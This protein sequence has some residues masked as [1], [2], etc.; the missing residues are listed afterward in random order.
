MTLLD[1]WLPVG[2]GLA[3]SPHCAQMCG[4]L[5]LAYS[6]GS[7]SRLRAHLFYNVGRIATYSLLGAVAGALGAAMGMIGKLAGIEQA[8][9][10]AAG[11]LLILAGFLTAGLVPRSGLAS[12]ANNRIASLFHKK[13]NR[14]IT[15]SNPL[16]K[17]GL[18]IALGFLPCG[19]VYAALLK[20]M[21][22]NGPAGGAVTMAL[23]GLGTSV[24]LVTIGA[25][26]SI[27]ASR[28]RR[29]SNLI[30]AVSMLAMG[31]LLLWHGLKPLTMQHGGPLH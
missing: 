7:Q 21:A 8:A 12:I 13:V 17:L 6:L 15:S 23:F 1:I 10:L 20:A 9:A 3:S 30:A 24:S 19:M 2:L 11:M 18:G 31:A 14:L 28:L 27:I 5:V 4:P 22:S 16:S 25:F 26:S 29:W